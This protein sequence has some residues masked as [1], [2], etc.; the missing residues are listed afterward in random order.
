MP[1]SSEYDLST[2]FT[3]P[4]SY[5]IGDVE[6]PSVLK[7]VVNIGN[8]ACDLEGEEDFS[9]PTFP[10]APPIETSLTM[11]YP[12][13]VQ[14]IADPPLSLVTLGH[15]RKVQIMRLSLVLMS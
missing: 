2:G 12:K 13:E 11:D 9:L 10:L 6:P 3:M 8:H 4:K 1:Y 7:H 5:A 14:I 15:L